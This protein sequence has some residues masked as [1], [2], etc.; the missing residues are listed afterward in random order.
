MQDLMLGILNHPKD[1]DRRLVYADW[2]EEQGK[3][4]R[5][6]F[7]RV[8]VEIAGNGR[9][10]HCSLFM[11]T[12]GELWS[13]LEGLK[14]HGCAG[15][16]RYATLRL[17]ERE[18]LTAENAMR[19]SFDELLWDAGF[20]GSFCTLNFCDQSAHWFGVRFERG[21]ISQ[22]GCTVTD[23]WH[24]GPLVVRHSPVE[25]IDFQGLPE[26]DG[27]EDV[28]INHYLVAE[29]SHYWILPVHRTD[30][31]YP[32]WVPGD[33]YPERTPYWSPG[34]SIAGNWVHYDSKDH[35]CKDLARRAIIWA[36]KTEP[37]QS[38]LAG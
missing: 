28:I 27:N 5:A 34:S 10:L 26:P 8:Q 22:V 32:H 36:K 17:R 21:F 25:T 38:K 13:D 12:C 6:E 1:N 20:K 24:Y 7:I 33:W 29:R 30:L 35:A 4:E 18:L 11:Y 15:C 3:S 31:K 23:W 16:Q 9:Q 14:E 37:D 19:W 2:L